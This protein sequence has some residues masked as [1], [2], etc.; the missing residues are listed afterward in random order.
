M[1]QGVIQNMKTL[2]KKK[3]LQK[4]VTER[5]DLLTFWK[6]LQCWTQFMKYE[7]RGN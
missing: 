6:K 5:T 7:L 3:L 4:L 2:Y 1:D